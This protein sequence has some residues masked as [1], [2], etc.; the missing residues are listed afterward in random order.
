MSKED[1]RAKQRELTYQVGRKKGKIERGAKEGKGAPLAE[2]AKSKT[3]DREHAKL[4]FLWKQAPELPQ[5]LLL[6]IL[7]LL[8]A[9]S[10][11]LTIL[12]VYLLINS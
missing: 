8:P 2:S 6:P 5:A 7:Y 10:F 11:L 9:I 3:A 12:L 4:L 1:K